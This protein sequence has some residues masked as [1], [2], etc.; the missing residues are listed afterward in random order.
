MSWGTERLEALKA[1]AADLP[2]VV[3]TLRLGGLDD[4]GEGW[5]RKTWSPAPGL[6]NGDGSMFGGYVAALADQ[7][8]AFAAMTVAPA[9][10]YFR[11]LNLQVNFARVGRMH[12]LVIEGRVVARTRQLITVRAALRRED[13]ELIAEAGAQQLLT[14]FG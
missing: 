3:R 8:L 9:D 11:T 7:T 6:E 14:P 10:A 13:G 1:G 5:V 4:W 12:P 2:P